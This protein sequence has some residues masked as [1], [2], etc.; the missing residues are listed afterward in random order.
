[1]L[2][3]AV[4]E[5]GQ[6][7][8]TGWAEVEAATGCALAE[9]EDVVAHVIKAIR[10]RVPEYA[11][12]PDDQLTAAVSRNLRD[13]L[14]AVRE[15]RHLGPAELQD[16]TLTVEE[17][18][19]NGVAIDDY[20]LAVATAESATW[21][22][23]LRR[24]PALSSEQLAE[25]TG[26]R[27]ACMNL[28]TRATASAH[29]RIELASARVDQERRAQA[30][31][32]LLRGGLTTVE[33][34]EQLARLGLSEA[35]TY[36]VVHARARGDVDL[37]KALSSPDA[38][39]VHWGE[40][41]VGLTRTVPPAR[42]D[43]TAGIAGPGPVTDLT[44]AHRLAEVAFETAWALGVTGVWDLE[45][46]GLMAAVQATPEVGQQLRRRYLDPL[47][48]SGNLGEELLATARAFL[49]SGSRRD[50]A[51]ERL[52]LHQNTVGYR[53]NRFT[54]LTGADLSELTTLAEL[55]WLFVDLD[56]RG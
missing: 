35:H 47:R 46:L 16:F 22:Q 12:V 51:A 20:L 7:G 44:D 25:A 30:L 56:L 26:I 29:R 14:T 32:T 34:R 31:R 43:V 8:A 27:L 10:E 15:R 40:N 23:V 24:A 21:E 38:A 48:A 49:E 28:V 53:L 42:K 13:L 50:L 17:R 41:T 33:A 9:L 39:F 19:R 1:M 18:A 45:A 5:D 11:L 54:E 3:R 2:G 37:M 4:R 55:H 52:H 36:Y 6:V